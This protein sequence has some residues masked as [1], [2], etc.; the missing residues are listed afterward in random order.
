MVDIRLQ[1][2]GTLPRLMGMEATPHQPMAMG[3]I[4]E[5]WGI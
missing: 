3:V 1:M 5:L 4:R 2:E